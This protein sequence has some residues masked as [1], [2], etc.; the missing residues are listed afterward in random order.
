MTYLGGLLHSDGR[1]SH[2][3]SRRLGK[4]AAEFHTLRRVWARSTL[5]LHRKLEIFAA[6]VL[7]TLTYGLRTTW[8]NAAS[9]RRIDGFQARC[10][11]K[12]QGIQHSYYSRVPNSEVLRRAGQ[13]ALS[14]TLLGQQMR[15]LGEIAC[16]DPGPI[17]D[18]IFK[19]GSLVLVDEDWARKQGRPRHTWAGEVLKRSLCAAGGS[20]NLFRILMTERSTSEWQAVVQ[21]YCLRQSFPE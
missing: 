2:E 17:R 10:L 3:L 11:R 20:A 7:S 4:A 18:S 6:C 16:R 13:K 1:S 15:F 14:L 5:S 9:R 12:L 19:P 8:L 21:A